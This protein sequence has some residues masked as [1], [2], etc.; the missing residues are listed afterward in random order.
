[1]RI[2]Y[3]QRSGKLFR[4]FH[5]HKQLVYKLG[6]VFSSMEEA[7]KAKLSPE[8][9]TTLTKREKTAEFT[10]RLLFDSSRAKVG[11]EIRCV[12]KVLAQLEAG[13]N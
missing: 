4:A 13:G 11:A 6:S 10:Q 1:M 8:E 9:Q 5:W 2:C 7:C 3:Y 12:N